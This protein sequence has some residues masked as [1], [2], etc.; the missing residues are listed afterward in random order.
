[1]QELQIIRSR[2]I[3]PMT[4]PTI[5]NGALVLQGSTIVA[6]NEWKEVSKKYSGNVIDL[7]EQVI[8]PGLINSH[9]HLDYTLMSGILGRP[10]SF[11]S[12]I[13]SMI[14]LKQ[15]WSEKDFQKSW[16]IGF[17]NISKTGTTWVA[18]TISHPT[19]FDPNNPPS[20]GSNLFPF[21]ELI[22]LEGSPLDSSILAQT[23]ESI[24][25]LLYDEGQRAGISPHAPYTTTPRLWESISNHPIFANSPISMHL[26]ESIEEFE[27]FTTGSGNMYDMFKA[28]HHLPQWGKG[29]PV[30]LMEEIGILEKGMIVVHAN[31]LKEGDAAHL[32]SNKIHVVHCPRSHAYFQHPSFPMAELQAHNINIALGTDSLASVAKDHFPD[33]LSLFHEMRLL[34]EGQNAVQPE[35]ILEMATLNGAKALGLQEEVGSLEPGKSADWISLP[36]KGKKETLMDQ[37]IGFTDHLNNIYIKGKRISLT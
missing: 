9:C 32:A 34:S 36:W 20:E 4:G 11:T 16:N 10:D 5:L 8:L 22:H 35:T 1:M 33:S 24:D 23:A 31:C 7:G 13:Q 37:V 30:Q 26:S 2:A 29:S 15:S 3:L 25:L 27:L 19:R 21:Y 12:W 17:Q 28:I 14:K 18:D 6:V